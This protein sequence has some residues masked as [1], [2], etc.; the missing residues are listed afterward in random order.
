MKRPLTHTF[1]S[2]ILV[3]GL[4]SSVSFADSTYTEICDTPARMASYLGPRL[5]TDAEA[6]ALETSIL[7]ANKNFT[8]KT[9]RELIAKDGLF[10]SSIYLQ[11]DAKAEEKIEKI[12]VLVATGGVAF[13]V[14]EAIDRNKEVADKD[15]RA[16]A[17]QAAIRESDRHCFKFLRDRST[18]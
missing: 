5:L 4:G 9:L 17:V 7:A 12:C 3:A 2:M 15:E 6:K 14:K 13:S 1:F 8:N 16:R 18:R 10:A 11:A